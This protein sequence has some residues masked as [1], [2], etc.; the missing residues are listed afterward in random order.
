MRVA[1]KAAL[2]GCLIL[3]SS[4]RCLAKE[5]HGIIPL[6]SSRADVERMIGTPKSKGEFVSS[7]EFDNEFVDIYYASGKPC[8]SGLTNSWKVARDIVVTI[9]II[10]KTATNFGAFVDDITKYKK[11]I[12]PT[13]KR[14]VYYDDAEQGIRYTV[15]EGGS[16]LKDVIS[17]DYVPSSSENRLKCSSAK[18]VTTP[19]V[20]PFEMFG[21]VSS[22]RRRAIL[23]NFAIQLSKEKTLSGLI[24]VYSGSVKRA[25]MVARQVRNYLINLRGVETNRL[26]IRSAKGTQLLVELYLVPPDRK[27]Q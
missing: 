16:S 18:S 6:R 22:V 4:I 12:D 21:N 10:P 5:W 8:G 3:L 7:Y 26:I 23:D 24:L 14:R 15:D 11:T 27:V 1:F 17:I 25:S 2:F 19:D 20:A 9:R 13:D